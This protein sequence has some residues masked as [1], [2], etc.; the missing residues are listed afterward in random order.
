MAVIKID[1][2]RKIGDVSRL[3][4]GNGICHIGRCIYGGIWDEKK[5][6]FNEKVIEAIKNEGVTIIRGPDGN[7]V[8]GYQWQ[9]GIGEKSSRRRKI[10]RIRRTP[11]TESDV[12]GTNE[13]IEFCRLINAEPCIE[14]NM[15]NDSVESAQA[16]VEYCNTNKDLYFPNLRKK[17]GYNDPFKVKYWCLGNEVQGKW[18]IGYMNVEEYIKKAL[19]YAKVVKGTDPE[20]KLTACGSFAFKDW[21]LSWDRPVIENLYDQ[22]DY[23]SLHLYLGNPEND[24]YMYMAKASE[25]E[26]WIKINRANIEAV[27]Y[28][29]DKKKDIYIAF[30][31]WGI[32]YK[33]FT[34]NMEEIYFNLDIGKELE[35]KE[36][37]FEEDYNLEDAMMYAL[38]MNAFIRNADIVKIACTAQSVNVISSL[39]VNSNNQDDI[40][41]Q[42]NYYPLALY[43]SHNG[44]I[45]IDSLVLCEDFI[46]NGK[47]YLYLDVST[48]LDSKN[49]TVILNVVN[50]NLN[51]SVST[52]IQCLHGEFLSDGESYEI[53]SSDIKD[54]NTFED[55]FK[56]TVKED[57]LSRV[58]NNFK[59]IFPPHSIT[60]LK[61][62][63]K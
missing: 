20:I 31:E 48:T 26:K 63:L 24:Y 29:F 43:S 10:D 19:D 44:D 8:D 35:E 51:E 40:L 34:K 53:T 42:A 45:S 2:D 23:L 58:K 39:M 47:N 7:L 52:D 38:Y 5:N 17:S 12:F 59:Y 15:C 36:L 13:F 56:I 46:V 14:I 30:D 50:R 41:L 11:A 6:K 61:L 55:K 9:N 62:K 3:I 37:F 28:V 16:W 18:N 25:V 21:L 22:I 32:W 49:N 60:V 1:P 33:T 57:K 54:K 27:K 4:Y